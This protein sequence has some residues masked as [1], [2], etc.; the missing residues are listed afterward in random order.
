MNLCLRN[1]MRAGSLRLYSLAN[2]GTVERARFSRL[3]D[4]KKG[5][6]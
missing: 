5:E 1:E 2:M 6:F 4:L 3:C